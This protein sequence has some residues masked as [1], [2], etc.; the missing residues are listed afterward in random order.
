MSLLSLKVCSELF[1]FL[2]VVVAA[3]IKKK[4][5][6]GTRSSIFVFSHLEQYGIR[7]HWEFWR[8]TKLLA[9]SELR[10]LEEIYHAL[11]VSLKTRKVTKVNIFGAFGS[12]AYSS[13]VC[14]CFHSS[15]HFIFSFFHLHKCTIS[16]WKRSWYAFSLNSNISSLLHQNLCKIRT[17]WQNLYWFS[18]TKF[19]SYRYF[20]RTLFCAG[21]IIC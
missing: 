13:P 16:C 14:L 12:V 9:T 20:I 6:R 5:G 15:V 4:F 2:R 10:G 8:I 11:L 21:S 19:W 18:T 3:Q 1:L 7:A 17:I